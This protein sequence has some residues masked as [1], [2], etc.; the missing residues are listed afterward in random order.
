[1]PAVSSPHPREA[2]LQAKLRFH[3]DDGRQVRERGRCA[4]QV[5]LA[6]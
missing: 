4:V 5:V 6:V 3:F 1:M 2:V